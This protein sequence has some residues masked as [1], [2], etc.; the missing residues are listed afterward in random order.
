MPTQVDADEAADEAERKR[1]KKKAWAK[2]AA[3]LGMNYKDLTKAQRK[4]FRQWWKTDRALQKLAK[5]R[6]GKPGSMRTLLGATAA[7]AGRAV[8]FV[9]D[10]EGKI[11]AGAGAAD[12]LRKVAGVSLRD[13]RTRN[14]AIGLHM[15][16]VGS[17]F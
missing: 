16:R 1:L 8:L 6:G 3:G 17:E 15:Q 14:A 7:P 13:E 12:E 11:G 9:P 10:D 5:I 2:R 4:E